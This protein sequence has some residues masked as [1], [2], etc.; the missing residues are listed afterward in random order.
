MKD[1]E[2]YPIRA[3]KDNYIWAVVNIK[4]NFLL[5]VDPGDALPVIN[6]IN[7]NSLMLSSIL[8]THH[9]ADHRDG[10]NVLRE[11]YA[12][13]VYA[14]THIDI[15][16]PTCIVDTVSNI[17]VPS[18]GQFKILRVPG[19][20]LDHVAYY[21]DSGILFCGDTLFSAGCGRVFEG[22]FEQMYR[23]L[24]LLN[25]LPEYTKIYC[26]HEYTL[27]N[28]LFAK[29]IEPNNFSIHEA[30]TDVENKR[31]NDFPTLPSTLSFE[32]KVNPFLRCH[33]PEVI[34]IAQEHSQKIIE[35]PV[36]VFREL[37]L[38]KNNFVA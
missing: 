19:H 31:K 7:L 15:E 37:R 9:H 14:P 32:R 28:L 2:I 29:S 16:N 22:T 11:K 13:A 4:T 5:V 26:A 35:T 34:K 17:N 6:F 25:S 33:V 8:V 1:I 27:S 20:T 3:F 24:E 21:H 23:S 12:P 38:W 10:I 18:F 30:I 36:D